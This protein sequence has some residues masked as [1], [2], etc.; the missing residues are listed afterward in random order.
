M[1]EKNSGWLWLG[2]PREIEM[3]PLTRIVYVEEWIV[4]CLREI[5][6][7]LHLFLNKFSVL[8]NDGQSLT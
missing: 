7:Y 1:V 3:I 8:C 5:L 2:S 6:G 4:S